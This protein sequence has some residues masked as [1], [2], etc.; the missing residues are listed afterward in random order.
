M[1]GKP[2]MGQMPPHIPVSLPRP[3]MPGLPM[4]PNVAQPNVMQPAQ[5]PQ[6]PADWNFS[7]F[8]TRGLMPTPP[9][10]AQQGPADWNFSNFITRGLMP[11]PPRQAQQG[12]ADWN[13]SNAITQGMRQPQ[14][15]MVAAMG[16]QP[17]PQGNS[18]L[19]MLMNRGDR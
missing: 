10:Q 1:F 12:P 13:F 18:M 11:T 6:G 9:Q 19:R 5:Q 16:G 3:G 7:N 14:G 4:Q 17:Q 2:M 8:I 15:G